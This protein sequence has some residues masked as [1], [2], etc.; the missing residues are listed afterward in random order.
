MKHNGPVRISALFGWLA[1]TCLTIGARS[2]AAELITFNRDIAPILFNNCVTCHRPG[3]VA[4]FSLETYREARHHA[5]DIADLT[6]SRTMPPWK[7]EL[8]FG[9]FRDVRRLT[10]AQIDLIQRWVKAGRPEGDAADL[11]PL[12]KFPAGWTLGQPDLIVKM[13]KAYTLRADGSDDYRCFVIPLHLKQNTYVTAVDFRPDNPRIVHHALFFLD[14]MGRGRD[15]EDESSDG[16]PG[17]YSAGGPGFLPSGGLGGWAPGVTPRFMPEGVGRLVRRGSDLVVQ[18]HFHPSGKIEHEQATFGLYFA[19][20]PPQKLLI[21]SDH[22]TRRIDIAPGDSHYVIDSK[23]T[24]PVNV[25]LAGVFPHAHLLC[26][27]IKVTA[28]LPDGKTLPLIWIKD[29]DWN[30]QGGYFY[31]KPIQ[32]PR[33]T[34]IRQQFIYDNS[35]GNIH[36][37][38]TPPKRVRYGEQTGDEM[39]LVFYDILI[40]RDALQADAR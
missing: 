26:R 2:P 21:G 25:E 20:T 40:N 5:K 19:K 24:V 6:L 29:W 12:P 38:N 37:P 18:I 27:Q 8:G 35:T 7:P 28:T 32:I 10:D 33:G 23:F 14:T 9:D 34:E 1:A 13:P 11:P 17:Y 31:R 3:E 4:P 30:W 39:S 16:L 22:S 15:L 36:N